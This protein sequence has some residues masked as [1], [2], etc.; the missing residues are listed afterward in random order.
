MW[1]G[2]TKQ[3]QPARYLSYALK[4]GAGWALISDLLAH[5]VGEGRRLLQLCQ[6]FPFDFSESSAKCVRSSLVKGARLSR[7]RG[8]SCREAELRRGGR[9]FQLVLALAHIQLSFLT[10]S[11]AN[12]YRLRPNPRC[13]GS[14]LQRLPQEFQP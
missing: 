14:S 12:L 9:S 7:H 5:F 3:Q 11:L 1:V 2:R 6:V 13:R 4:V 8:W 10:A